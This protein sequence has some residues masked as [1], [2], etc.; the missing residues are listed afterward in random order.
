MNA[1]LACPRC[2]QALPSVSGEAGIF[3]TCSACNTPCLAMLR[4]TVSV[5][6]AAP[7]PPAIAAATCFF[8]ENN[9]AAQLCSI[10]GRF[11]CSLCDVGL[12]E[13][14]LCP[15]CF[16]QAQERFAIPSLR[17]DDRLYDTMAMT[18]GWAWLLFY[19]LWLLALPTVIYLTVA[20]WRAPRHYLVRRMPWRYSVALAGVVLPPT[21]LMIALFRLPR[22][23]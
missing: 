1:S 13:Q 16:D 12:E 2:G 7:P 11:L 5:A 21:L 20:K 22:P 4:E 10:C 18:I 6:S 17:R 19:P 9:A 3:V 23:R 14:H 15:T 8:H